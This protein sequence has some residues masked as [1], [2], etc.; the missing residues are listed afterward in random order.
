M[1]KLSSLYRFRGTVLYLAMSS[2]FL[3]GIFV[4]VAAPLKSQSSPA[5]EKAQI[6][7][8]QID[9]GGKMAFDVASVKVNN[10]GPGATVHWNMPLNARAAFTPTGGLFSVSNF[11]LMQYLVFAYRLSYAQ[12]DAV[13]KQL[14]AWAM[15]AQYDIEGRAA[16]N[17]T[18]DQYRL[19]V[20]SL[21]ADRFK[22]AAHYE[23]KQTPVLALVLVK[24][25]TLGPQIREYPAGQRVDCS[26]SYSA[27]VKPW[28][29]L[30]G[31][32]PDMC[33][34]MEGLRPG[35]GRVRDG[36][37]MVPAV[38]MADMFNNLA[39]ADRPIVDETGLGVVDFV[40]EFVP[41][42]PPNSQAQMDP[43]GPTFLE[44]LKD[45]LG[46]KLEPRVAPVQWLIVDHIEQ[47]TPN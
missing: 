20:Q 3:S 1:C 46:M 26:A 38:E 31:V 18:K 33:D 42:M 37:V 30:V 41:N 15:N 35:P 34:V 13:K 7:Q 22:L 29:S 36:S 19:M 2:V 47:P 6:P 39:D 40:I 24:P 14:P 45:Q 32:A 4:F 12:I 5:A 25:E 23:T 21:F 9:A 27:P 28:P 8:W 10:S 44:A 11:S 43:N 17:P 16:G